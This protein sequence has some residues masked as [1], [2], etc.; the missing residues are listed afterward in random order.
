MSSD[1]SDSQETHAKLLDELA[2]ELRQFHAHGESFFRAAAA[3]TG[4]TVTDLQ[5]IDVLDSLGPLTAGQIAE[6]AGLT[7]GAITGMINRLE[8]AGIVRREGD[9]NDKR[10]VIV[11]LVRDKDTMRQID[12][13]FDSIGQAWEDVAADYSDEQIAFLVDFLKRSN[14]LSQQ[15]IVQLRAAPS[16]EK[17]DFSAP[18]GDLTSG[19][20]VATGIAELTVRAGAEIEALYT[21]RFEGPMPEVKVSGGVVTLR[22]PRRLTWLPITVKRKAEVTLN[23]AIPWQIALQ[24]GGSAIDAELGNLDLAGIE[25]KGGY[26]M[27]RLDLPVPSGMVPVQINGA[28]S[29]IS[30][31]RPVGVPA[32]VHLKGWASVFVFDEQNFTNLGNDVRLQSPGYDDTA[33]HYDIEVAAS[34]STVSI[35]TD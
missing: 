15:E 13:I 4:M 28:A 2:R 26:S 25:V 34:V 6:L 29:E 27:I 5:V 21:A 33:P 12:S 1:S 7:T 16:S 31:Q 10:R 23:S 32:R 24:G 3:R 20:F 9:P 22:Y 30:V 8:E 19:R 11:K 35:T 17:G 18:L 14:A